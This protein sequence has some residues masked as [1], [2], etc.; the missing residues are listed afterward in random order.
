MRLRTRTYGPHL[1]VLMLMML[2]AVPGHMV[3]D[4]CDAPSAEWSK[5]PTP[6]HERLRVLPGSDIDDFAIA[7]SDGSTIY[8]IGTC[9]SPC[10][11]ELPPDPFTP[12]A[13]IFGPGQTPRFWKSGDGGETWKD[14]TQRLLE[15]RGLPALHNHAPYADFLFFT[16]VAAP[17]DSDDVVMIAGYNS[18]GRAVVVGS[19]DGGE[20]FHYTGCGDIAGIITSAVLSQETDTG[21]VAAVGTSDTAS[22]GK[23]WTFEPGEGWTG[24]WTD[25]STTPGWRD[26]SPWHGNPL[27]VSAVVSLELSPSFE[28][29]RSLVGLAIADAL[30]E[31]GDAY[32]GFYLVKGRLDDS[33]T[34]NEQAGNT[35]FP[36]LVRGDDSIFHVPSPLPE[37]LLRT[38]ADLALPADYDADEEDSPALVAINGVERNPVDDSTREEGGFIFRLRGNEVGRDL[39]GHEGNPWISSVAY[40]GAA[41]M[42][43]ATLLGK[44]YPDDWRWS[45]IVDWFETNEPDLVCCAG[46][47]VLRGTAVEECC[48][49]WSAANPAPSG[50]YGV[51]VA[52]SPDGTL[53]YASTNGEGR[54]RHDGNWYAD[55]SAFSRSTGETVGARWEQLGLV[56][57]MINEIED[58]NYDPDST[59]LHVHTSHQEKEGAVCDCESIWLTVDNGA[60]YTRVL[61][62]RP[63]ISEADEEAFDDIIDDYHRGFYRPRTEG[64]LQTGGVRYVIGDAID[65]DDEELLSEDFAADAVY[66]QF[67]T[68][69][70]EWERMSA[71]VLDYRGLRLMD[72]EDAE[73]SVL[74]VGFDNLWWDFTE[75]APMAYEEDGTDPDCPWGH[76]CRKLSG[77]ARCLDPDHEPCCEAPEWDYLIRG[78]L[79]TPLLDGTREHLEIA[80]SNCGR[81]AIRLWAIDRENGY[82]SEEGQTSDSYDWC[83]CEFYNPAWGRLWFYDDCLALEIADSIGDTMPLVP[84]DP[85]FCQNEE[86][87]LD[88]S[89][90]CC[91]CEYE[92]QV[93]LDRDFRHT[94]L[95]TEDALEMGIDDD[96][97]RFYVPNEPCSPSYLVRQGALDCNQEHWW[98]VRA[99]VAATGEVIR[100]FWSEPLSFRTAPG[101]REPLLLHTPCDGATRVPTKDVAFSWQAVSG[102]TD[103]DF[104]LVDLEHGH[105]A[106]KV[107]DFTSVML[108]GPLETDTSYIWR[109]LALDGDQVIGKS[110]EA[111]FRTEPPRT[112]AST[113]TTAPS[114]V[115]PT[116]SPGTDWLPIFAAV[117]ALLLLGVLTSLSYVNVQQRRLSRRERGIWPD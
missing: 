23:V 68:A 66:R 97:R 56:D 19:D 67:E 8:A 63:E 35:G 61:V 59:W 21:R 33:A 101:P 16:A 117:L 92:L 51:Q 41:D 95:R 80:G 53:A 15:A 12:P 85:C 86:F 30:E 96:D 37:F 3:A 62:G 39:L 2:L 7:G 14:L 42:A 47:T 34:W 13:G 46:C 109:V 18:E 88:W 22:G 38:S 50:Q 112:A 115:P 57:T 71:I 75:N 74:Y 111:T 99:R 100:S 5:Y 73:G 82:W 48:P 72:C 98:R 76:D 87:A 78:L 70:A 89:R 103:Y 9:N 17:P 44:A 64:A 49:K 29:D 106:S 1:V 58:I 77:A 28:S 11:G 10:A 81:D 105:V 36:V 24:T 84:S 113:V 60:T 90:P 108:P 114:Y 27:A 25:T 4:N 55:E 31:D 91:S 69:G 54:I 6:T 26:A 93:A 102:V 20:V 45:D 83:N 104:M 65:E 32:A 116:G 110:G 107:G 40:H 52:F 43:G 79:G 94:V